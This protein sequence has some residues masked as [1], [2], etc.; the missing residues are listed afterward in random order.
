MTKY[1]TEQQ[2]GMAMR[3]VEQ[4]GLSVE[5]LDATWKGIVA[6]DMMGLRVRNFLTNRRQSQI[7][8]LTSRLH[9]RAA[10]R[11]AE[12]RRHPHLKVVGE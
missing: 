7:T 8:K 1:A 6:P 5:R 4:A 11:I 2:I 9:R 10:Q 3:Y 12:L